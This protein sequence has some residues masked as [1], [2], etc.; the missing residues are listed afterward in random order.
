[1]PFPFYENGV[2]FDPDNARIIVW[3]GGEDLLALGA[4]VE[5]W[6]LFE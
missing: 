4:G 1:M 3:G 2:V 5:L 6:V